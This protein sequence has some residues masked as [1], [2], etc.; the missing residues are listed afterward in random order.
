VSRSRTVSTAWTFTA[1]WLAMALGVLLLTGPASAHK[2]TFET[3]LQFK[4]RAVSDGLNQYEGRVVSDRAKCERKRKV[5][6][7][8]F[9]IRIASTV[10]LA[11][12]SWAALGGTAHPPKGTTLIAFTPRKFLKRSRK[13]RHKCASDFAEK[14]AP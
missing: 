14:K 1:L 13:H 11:S 8:A 5:H 9:D 6:V 3:T 4:V 10:S 12:G 2:R 7:D